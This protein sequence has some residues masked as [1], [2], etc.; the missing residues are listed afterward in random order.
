MRGLILFDID[1]T[2]VRPGDHVHQLAFVRAL[3]E[4]F[5]VPVTLDGVPLSGML[6][7]QIAR[8]A[9]HP[10]G[11]DEE[12]VSAGLVEMMAAMGRHYREM[13]ATEERRTWLLPGVVELAE[14][15][16]AD[17]FA[18]G[19][20]TGNA[21]PV[22]R[23]KLEAAGV[24]SLFPIGAYGDSARVRGDLVPVALERARDRYR[25]EFAT[26]QT[27]LIGDT[28]RDIEAARHAGAGAFSVATGRYSMP[29]LQEHEPDILLPDLGDTRRALRLIVDWL[30]D[31]RSRR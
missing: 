13:I 17:G 24:A 3:Q 18:L 19:V 21:T 8:M 4:V 12:R 29:A 26:R 6:D 23:A 7:S 22:A 31:G 14:S 25:I 20:L 11:V 9:L 28:P 16:R 10:Y 5:E 15:L 27:L 2:I 1:G 30:G